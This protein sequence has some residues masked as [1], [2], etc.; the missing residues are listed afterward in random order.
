M[1]QIRCMKIHKDY[2]NEILYHPGEANMVVDSLSHKDI[3]ERT[4]AWEL[5]MKIISSI[6]DVLRH[7][8]LRVFLNENLKE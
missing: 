1:Q 5:L 3:S 4:W 6:N 8:Q 7:T 2:D